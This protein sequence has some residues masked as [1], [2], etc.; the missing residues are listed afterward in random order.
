MGWGT[1]VDMPNENKD[2]NVLRQHGGQYSMTAYSP[3]NYLIHN[4]DHM[5]GKHWSFEVLRERVMG[6][7][8][9]VM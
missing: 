3:E 5:C 8:E 4:R 2:V 7:G 6:L 9:A 1:G